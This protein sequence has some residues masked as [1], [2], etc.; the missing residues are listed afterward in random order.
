[1]GS[2]KNS[3]DFLI[4]PSDS[5]NI[6]QFNEIPNNRNNIASNTDIVQKMNGNQKIKLPAPI[7]RHPGPNTTTASMNSSSKSSSTPSPSL[8]SSNKNTDSRSFGGCCNNSLMSNNC[9]FNAHLYHAYN[10][11]KT[12]VGDRISINLI[13][14][15]LR[16][17]SLNSS[18]NLI[19]KLPPLKSITNPIFIN[20]SNN[21]N[22]IEK[23][24]I[25]DTNNLQ[26]YSYNVPRYENPTNAYNASNEMTTVKREPITATTTTTT[27]TTTSLSSS[28]SSSSSCLS[29]SSSSSSSS[30]NN[31]W[32]QN[33]LDAKNNDF[34]K[35]SVSDIYEENN[36]NKKRRQRAGPSCDSCRSRKVKCDAE[37]LI[38]DYEELSA[39]EKSIFE[40]PIREANI[41]NYDYKKNPIFKLSNNWRI[42]KTQLD[43]IN[44]YKLKN[45]IKFV[46]YKICWACESRNFKCQFSKGF[47]RIHSTN[48]QN[49]LSLVSA[50]TNNDNGNDNE[51]T[52]N[53]SNTNIST[54]TSTSTSTS[55]RDIVNSTNI[56]N[57]TIKSF[58]ETPKLS[59]SSS[60]SSSNEILDIQRSKS[61]SLSNRSG[62]NKLKTSC[63]NCR[64]KKIKCKKMENQD[65]SAKCFNCVKKSI[66]CN[67][68]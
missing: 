5:S 67:Y 66:D 53:N 20:D 64:S 21:N 14:P 33:P 48:S 56:N 43:N 17:P 24:H 3:I 22:N 27:T 46:K 47:T 32:N 37:I 9:N 10:N 12:S 4:S 50:N 41:D 52:R 51:S 1:M 55:A 39:E 30:S 59:V 11:S 35:R 38:L 26:A 61:M 31:N 13:S 65:S 34:R 28:L 45:E 16:L 54:S 19:E 62:N 57:N 6:K 58:V 23:N 40:K 60:A 42:V 7:I 63:V 29:S 68:E 44:D 2:P 49:S 36:L 15:F 8:N 25:G 18:N